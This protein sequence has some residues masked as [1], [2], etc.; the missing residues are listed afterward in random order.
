M[1]PLSLYMHWSL[2]WCRSANFLMVKAFGCRPVV[3]Y[4]DPNPARRGRWRRAAVRAVHAAERRACGGIAGKLRERASR[5]PSKPT[6][7]Q[8]VADSPL[9]GTRFEPSVPPT[10]FFRERPRFS[11]ISSA[12]LAIPWS[13]V[14]MRVGRV[15][16]LPRARPAAVR[17][18]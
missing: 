14:P 4:P 11:S 8:F 3:T 17:P 2:R 6:A 18:N 12:R 10:R 15:P 16:M 7:E 1:P 13:R 5:A 9:E